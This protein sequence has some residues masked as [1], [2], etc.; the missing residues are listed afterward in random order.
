[1]ETNAPTAVKSGGLGRPRTKQLP[2]TGT[3]QITFRLPVEIV[4]QLDA[5]AERIARENFGVN[6][7][8]TEIIRQIVVDAMGKRSKRPKK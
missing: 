8:R 7:E 4:R 3:V 6:V 1:M 5:E 2:D